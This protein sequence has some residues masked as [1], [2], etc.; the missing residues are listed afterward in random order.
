VTTDSRTGEVSPGGNTRRHRWVDTAARVAWLLAS[1]AAAALLLCF[2]RHP[3]GVA[4]G[5]SIALAAALAVLRPYYTLL[6]LA[7]FGPL[8]SVLFALADIEAGGLRL[9]EAMVLTLVIGWTASHALRP[10]RVE[11]P[12]MLRLGAAVLL[13]AALASTVVS[14][15]IAVAEGLGTVSLA[16]IVPGVL[17]SY[18]VEWN[19]VTAAMM[20]AEGVVLVVA[21]ADL[22]AGNVQRRGGVLRIMFA[23]AAAAASLNVL[24]LITISIDDEQPWTAL[25]TYFVS[26]R[27]NVH[28]GDLNAA[29]SYFAMMLP[30]AVG[31]A[32]RARVFSAMSSCVIAI[33]LWLTGSRTALA[34]VGIATGVVALAA[35]R[36]R[37]RPRA[38]AI[39]GAL[40]VC[41]AAAALWV[42]SPQ[43]RNIN[44]SS[45]VLIRFD[46][47]RVALTLAADNPVFGVGLGQFFDL[48]GTYTT[49]PLYRTGENAHNNFLQVLAELGVPGL[50]LFLLVIGSAIRQGWRRSMPFDP[51]SGMLTG[52][53][54]FL[55]TC[56]GGHPL[57]VLHAAYPFW[58]AIGVMGASGEARP[59]SRRLALITL[60]AV[61]LLAGSLPFRAAAAVRAANL[62]NTSIGFSIWHRDSGGL[63]YR[64]AGGRSS[65]FVPASARAVRIPLR[66][67][68]EAPDPIEVRI[69]LD[70]REANRVRLSANRGWQNV[71]LL[72]PSS[73]GQAFSRIDLEVTTPGGPV[74]PGEA[75]RASGLLSV[76]RPIVE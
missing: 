29:G 27:I 51:Q 12:P 5:T 3:I 46:M 20:F 47:A 26:Q 24:R 1:L 9:S 72:I 69:L 44:P 68:P 11:V 19:A 38:A 76:G 28:Y 56:I 71:L 37:G 70:G 35:L 58:L 39:V 64:W 32:T 34:A 14:A 52:L 30:L 21:A 60:L 42:L 74:L 2:Y 8:A 54:A 75:K 7:G 31:F 40:G 41:G 16:G 55:A 73:D 4:A 36:D 43:G 13:A 22:C 57:L 63:R 48:A 6:L 49:I 66:H 62:E 10:R 18:A 59:G 45:A 50:L 17:D 67:G 33:A 53:L 25:W 65:F 23:G 61:A 15:T